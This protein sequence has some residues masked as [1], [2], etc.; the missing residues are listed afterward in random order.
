MCPIILT[1]RRCRRVIQ[2]FLI[3]NVP[4]INRK[5]FIGKTALHLAIYNRSIACTDLLLTAP[6]V[7]PNIQ[8]Y[9]E[10]FSSKVDGRISD[11]LIQNILEYLKPACRE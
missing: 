10:I 3:F 1:F 4:G 8:V 5:N 2:E 7:N 11:R 9:C 6:N